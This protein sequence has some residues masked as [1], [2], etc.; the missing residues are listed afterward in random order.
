M[1]LYLSTE[2]D[3]NIGLPTRTHLGRLV[4]VGHREG[5]H[6]VHVGIH[7]RRDDYERAHR[8]ALQ[9]LKLIEPFVEEHKS[10][11]NQN[12]RSEERRVGKEC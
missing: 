3:Q 8:V 10:L 2:D 7:K 9:H 11:I 6:D 4:G 5:C 1:H 12:Y